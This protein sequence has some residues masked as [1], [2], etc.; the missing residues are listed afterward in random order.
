MNDVD[1][2]K[3]QMQEAIRDARTR[4]LIEQQPRFKELIAEELAKRT[5]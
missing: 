1:P 5:R 3:V 4:L 2:V